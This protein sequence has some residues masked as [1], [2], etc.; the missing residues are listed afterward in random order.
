MEPKSWRREELSHD[1]LLVFLCLDA[2]AASSLAI[3]DLELHVKLAGTCCTYWWSLVRMPEARST[4]FGKWTSNLDGDMG[5]RRS[6]RG[7]EETRR[8]YWEIGSKD[9]VYWQWVECIDKGSPGSETE[10]FEPPRW[11]VRHGY[12]FAIRGS[13]SLGST[14]HS[15]GAK[16]TTPWRLATTS[17]QEGK[18]PG[19]EGIVKEVH[20]WGFG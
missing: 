4:K 5:N 7:N 1:E 16:E 18:T 17:E 19:R 14:G 15:R 13:S 2:I 10:R 9:W 20:C 3:F 8:E 12:L 6:G 11:N